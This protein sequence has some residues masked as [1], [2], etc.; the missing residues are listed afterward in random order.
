[1]FVSSSPG[2]RQSLSFSPP[3][4]YK[5]FRLA[6]SLFS[7]G[8]LVCRLSFWRVSYFSCLEI[9][10][11]FLMERTALPDALFSATGGPG[12]ASLSSESQSLLLFR[13]ARLLRDF[14]TY[15]FAKV[16]GGTWAF[17]PSS[18]KPPDSLLRRKYKGFC[19]VL[20]FPYPAGFEHLFSGS[21][22]AVL[23][24]GPVKRPPPALDL[25][26]PSPL[27]AS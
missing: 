4:P 16:V 23:P 3:F 25:G 12:P 2:E 24:P 22:A 27:V 15:F 10:A 8:N 9:R 21:K 13:S 18:P 6:S 5:L 11:S 20:D 17:F 14:L 19:R 1:L 7:S 26:S